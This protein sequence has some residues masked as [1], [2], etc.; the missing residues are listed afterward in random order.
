MPNYHRLRGAAPE[1]FAE[2]PSRLRGV[3]YALIAGSV[4][5]GALIWATGLPASPSLFGTPL[6]DLTLPVALLVTFAGISLTGAWTAHTR[7]R[8]VEIVVASVLGVTG[9]VFFWV[10]SHSW[11]VITGPLSFYPP[12]S[13]VLAGLWLLP[14]VL[15]GLIVRKPGAAIYVELVAATLEALLGNKWGF[16]TVWYGLLEGLGAE[17]VLALLLYRGFGL[18]PAMLTGAGAGVA[19]GLL[20][21]FIYFPEFS[22]LYKGVYL[23]LA[24]IS[25]AVIAGIGSWALARALAQAGA[26]T[27]LASGRTSLR[28]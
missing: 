15:G 17:M 16:S 25:G 14:G 19:V 26:L 27:P 28:V 10:V 9:G 2:A 20:D 6:S 13:A 3:H 4:A 21:S 12:A 18:L 8:V 23:V 11:D 1:D 7:W 24:V 5:V 22:S